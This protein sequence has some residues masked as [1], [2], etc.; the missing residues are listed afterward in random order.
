MPSAESSGIAVTPGQGQVTLS[1][2][3]AT[4]A[5]SFSL[6]AVDG[7]LLHQG[8]IAPGQSRTI[9]LPAGIYVVGGV[10]FIVK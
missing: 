6:R 4:S 9:V 3:S 2:T 5:T 10:K 1:A 8:T 7:R